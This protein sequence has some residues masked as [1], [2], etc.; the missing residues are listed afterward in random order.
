M[1]VQPL[2][3]RVLITSALALPLVGWLSSRSAGAG[4]E[5]YSGEIRGV[6]AGGYDVVAYAE[7]GRAEAGSPRYTHNWKGATWRFASA[8]RRDS[9]A[10]AP[11]KFAP[12]YGGH[13]SWAASQGY[14]ASGDPLQWRIVGGRLFLNYNAD[15]HERWQKDMPGFI[16]AA[17]RSWPAIADR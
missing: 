4:S 8:A 17:D 2:T 7:A 9:F 5:I 3:R 11:E 16:A 15:I 13:C 12:A 14:K 6:A 10:A 1:A